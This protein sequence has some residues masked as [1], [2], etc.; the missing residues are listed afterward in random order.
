MKYTCYFDEP[1][2]TLDSHRGMAHHLHRSQP[3]ARLLQLRHRPHPPRLLLP[4]VQSQPQDSLRHLAREG[5]PLGFRASRQQ[6]PQHAGSEERFQDVVPE[7]WC[8][9]REESAADQRPIGLLG[10]LL[11]LFSTSW[12]ETYCERIPS[13]SL[14]EDLFLLFA[15]DFT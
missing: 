12:Q 2:L 6:I 9:R 13:C 3:Q 8:R 5:H 4:D 15:I 7:P 11:G 1:A 14:S 10:V